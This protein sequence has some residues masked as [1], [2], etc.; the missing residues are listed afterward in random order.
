MLKSVFANLLN[1]KMIF[2]GFAIIL[3]DFHIEIHM[4]FAI[5]IT[6]QR[7]HRLRGAILS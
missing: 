6:L 3:Q 5:I 1:E 2:Y 4:C 7:L